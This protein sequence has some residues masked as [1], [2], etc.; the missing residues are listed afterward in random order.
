MNQLT[1]AV[2]TAVPCH[3]NRCAAI[4]PRGIV[5]TGVSRSR[6]ATAISCRA[7]FSGSSVIPS[8]AA[9]MSIDCPKPSPRSSSIGLSRAASG[10]FPNSMI[11]RTTNSAR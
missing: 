10:V 4:V 9:T 11:S 2:T 3:V 5:P 1:R 8:P 6:V 7:R